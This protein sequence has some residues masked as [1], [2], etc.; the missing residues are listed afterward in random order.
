MLFACGKA[1]AAWEIDEHNRF[2]LDGEPFFPLGLYVAQCPDVDQS[3]Q[4]DQITD[5]PFDTLLNYPINK[6][7]F[8]PDDFE[9]TPQQIHDYMNAL[10][11]RGLKLIFSLHKGIFSNC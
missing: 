4:L 9:P 1:S 8:P 6:C 10:T 3:E 11:S 5:G 2:I 7:G